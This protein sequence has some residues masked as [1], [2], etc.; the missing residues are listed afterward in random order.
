MLS[1]SSLKL[2]VITQFTNWADT[3][4]LQLAADS[5]L[6]QPMIILPAVGEKKGPT[7]TA[8]LDSSA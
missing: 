2:V 5:F 8:A 4:P 3:E 1:F 7:E 6:D